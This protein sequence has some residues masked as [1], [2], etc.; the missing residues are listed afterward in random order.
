MSPS[1]IHIALPHFLLRAGIR[2]IAERD[3]RFEIV[4]ESDHY[5]ATLVEAGK[6]AVDVLICDY[7]ADGWNG[8]EGLAHLRNELK[9]CRFLI[10][11]N[12]ND[13]ANVM[14]AIEWKIP[15]FLTPQCDRAEMVNALHAATR[16][17][18]FYC[19]KVLQ[20]LLDKSMGVEIEPH[21][22]KSQL[23]NR[24]L[25]I[26][27]LVAEGHS[28]NKIGMILHLSPH[29]VYTHRKNIMRKLKLQ[30]TPELIRY[31]INQGISE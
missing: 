4:G 23:S 2:Y 14:K 29:T 3:R 21:C 31:A 16:G 6:T 28:A 10:I 20:L 9:N 26:V 22:K 19:N 27:K 15:G 1:R 7:Q 25:E 11:S 8:L 17:E 5:E 30:S 24:E 13:P 18:R 12:D